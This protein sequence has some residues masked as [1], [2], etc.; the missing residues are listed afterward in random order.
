MPH[1]RAESR[2]RSPAVRAP[3]SSARPDGPRRW[4][5]S[6]QAAQSPTATTF[7][8]VG[9]AVGSA[10]HA[11]AELRVR[12]PAAIRC[13]A[14]R[15]YP[16]RRRR[17]ADGVRRRGRRPVTRSAQS[18]LR[19]RAMLTGQAGDADATDQRRAVRRVR[20]GDDGAE[21]RTELDLQRRRRGLDDGDIHAEL[22]GGRGDL[23]ADEP[24]A[25]DDQPSTGAKVCTQ[26]DR[27][28]DGA[29]ARARLPW[30]RSRA[31]GGPASRWRSPQ[32]SAITRLPSASSTAPEVVSSLV[33]AVA[34][35]PFSL[36]IVVVG[37][38]R[39]I[40]LGRCRRRG[41]PSTAADGRKAVGSRRRRW[42]G[43]RRSPAPGVRGL[44]TDPRAMPR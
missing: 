23:G 10:E 2:R 4:T 26:R 25:D 44:R 8:T 7:G 3:R 31:S 18:V 24:G 5:E 30:L 20:S 29:D 19:R 9:L 11:I 12:C 32:P 22:A 41:I 35:Q 1:R 17:Q 42:S 13:W 15:R 28:V 37:L 21:P 40:G 16:R 14:R 33:A 27:V 39:Q 36:Q 6:C 38:E 43:A 34:Q